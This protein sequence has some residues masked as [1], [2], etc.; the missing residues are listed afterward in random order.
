MDKTERSEPAAPAVGIP[1]E[2]MVRPVSEARVSASAWRLLTRGEPIQMGDEGLQDD[3]TTW[4]PVIGWEV[5]MP[6]NPCFL[7]PMRRRA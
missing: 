2:R 5:G 6:Y 1:V 3:C 4:L 7:V